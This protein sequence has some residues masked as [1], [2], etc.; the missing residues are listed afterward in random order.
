MGQ[1][2]SRSWLAPSPRVVVTLKVISPIA[3]PELTGRAEAACACTGHPTCCADQPHTL[4]HLPSALW[5][6]GVE[7]H[8]QMWKE[9]GSGEFVDSPMSASKGKTKAGPHPRASSPSAGGGAHR[10]A[11]EVALSTGGGSSLLVRIS[12]AAPKLPLKKQYWRPS[13]SGAAFQGS[14][15]S[16]VPADTAPSVSIPRNAISLLPG[17]APVASPRGLA[18]GCPRLGPPQSLRHRLGLDPV[19][20]GA[21]SFGHSRCTAPLQSPSQGS[22]LSLPRTAK[23]SA[24]I[25][26]LAQSPLVA[27]CPQL[28]SF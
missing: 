28:V 26:L 27:P 25:P 12:E 3:L 10:A 6:W 17:E 16:V 13:I 24:K 9:G 18:L 15:A 11:G 1:S 14:P 4:V 8:F 5:G 23:F 7:P 22:W 20:G 21:V 19:G 2:L